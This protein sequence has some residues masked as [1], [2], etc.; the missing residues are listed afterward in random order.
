MNE[1]KRKKKGNKRYTNIEGG[2]KTVFVY[3]LLNCLENFEES[4]TLTM[5]SD[6]LIDWLIV[7]LMFWGLADWRDIIHLGASQFL[8]E[9][10]CLLLETTFHMQIYQSWAHTPNHILYLALKLQ[11]ATFLCL[12]HL[13]ASYQT[14]RESPYTPEILEIQ[15]SQ[16]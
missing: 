9:S 15:T 3:K 2:S 7:F 11:E 16:S 4:I 13:R 8:G 6:W 1:D 5:L 10:K 12:N 14:T